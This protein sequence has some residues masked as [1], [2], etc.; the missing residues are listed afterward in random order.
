MLAELAIGFCRALSAIARRRGLM[1][2][3]QILSEIDPVTCDRAIVATVEDVAKR[4]GVPTRRLP[5]GAAHD[6]QMMA[7]LAP[8][9]MIF[10]P[11]K[12][13]RSHSAA[14]WT[15]WESIEIGANCLLGTLYS[16]AT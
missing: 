8:I 12:D 9:G 5:S 15:P 6:A 14:E 3:Y 11:S 16:L 1:F 10:V 2:E 13:G 7:E 4:L